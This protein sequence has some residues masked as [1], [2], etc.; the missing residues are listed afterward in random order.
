[1]DQRLFRL[2]EA[3]TMGD[4]AELKA[5]QNEDKLILR[6][7]SLSSTAETPLHVA[8]L[9]GHVDFVREIMKRVPSFAQEL[10]RDGFAP[11]HLATA[12]GHLE[13]VR[14]LLN[15]GDSDLCLL[16]DKAGRTPLHH[17]AMK[18]R[19]QIIDELLSKCP[20]QKAMDQVTPNGE[21]VLHLTVK[22]SQ[23]E[24]FK[25]LFQ[26]SEK[27]EDHKGRV[28]AKDNEGKTVLEIVNAT[29]QLQVLD[30]I[31]H[32]SGDQIIIVEEETQLD[33][34]VEGKQ[35]DLKAK[36]VFIIIKDIF[37]D[38]WGMYLKDKDLLPVMAAMIAA[39]TFQ[40]GLNPPPIIWQK[41]V[42]IDTKCI[43]IA[44]FFK[45][46]MKD[47]FGLNIKD[48]FELRSCPASRFYGFMVCNTLAFASSLV[49]IPYHQQA[50]L[51]PIMI[52]TS[53]YTVLYTYLIVLGSIFPTVSGLVFTD[54]V[55]SLSLIP[56][57]CVPLVVM[58]KR[59]LKGP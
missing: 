27:L 41:G 22:N 3:A 26:A 45:N 32:Q 23:F 53:L 28:N 4:V 25:V 42:Q 10:N 40:A 44:H 39:A 18:G 30:L 5:L 43:N 48:P 59:L 52:I 47:P 50:L 37:T 36:D 38:S 14:E 20:H 12:A 24:A 34:K 55:V 51:A 13:V 19:I 57:I 46:Y 15:K 1:M 35:L 21:T 56:L 31:R 9:A 16:K 33:G 49:L 11:I 7:V 58:L 54:Y 6:R 17:A 8:S 2:F 29:N